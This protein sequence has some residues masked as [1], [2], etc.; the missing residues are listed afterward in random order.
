MLL[1]GKGLFIESAEAPRPRSE[2]ARKDPPHAGE[3]IERA[4]ARARK[5]KVVKPAAT[6]RA[7]QQP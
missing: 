2:G 4:K 3:A 1:S 7:E 5:R 6:E